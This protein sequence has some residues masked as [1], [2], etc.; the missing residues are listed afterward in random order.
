[1][2]S[3]YVDRRLHEIA[4]ES[5]PSPP[6]PCGKCFPRQARK[7]APIPRLE[8]IERIGSL[9]VRKKRQGANMEATWFDVAE[10]YAQGWK[11]AEAVKK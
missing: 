4:S 11:D 7:A 5:G 6:A 1:M 10:A 8:T 2:R 3:A 9:Y